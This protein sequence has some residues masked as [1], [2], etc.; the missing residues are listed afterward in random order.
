MNITHIIR[1]EE[2]LSSTPKHLAIYQ[3]FGWTPPIFSHV[4]LMVNPDGS[5]ISKRYSDTYIQSYIDKG[6][7]SNALLNYVALIGWSPR[8]SNEVF[9]MSELIDKV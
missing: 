3:A 5:K 2:W 4:S 9:S 8:T 1:G 6:Y 7:S